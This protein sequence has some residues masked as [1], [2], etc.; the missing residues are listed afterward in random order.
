MTVLHHMTQVAP[1]TSVER[2]VK[3]ARL[4]NAKVYRDRYNWKGGGWFTRYM[5]IRVWHHNPKLWW[6]EDASLGVVTWKG[7]I[8]SILHEL[9]GMDCW[10]VYESKH[11][12][13]WSL[14]MRV[15]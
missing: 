8:G 2:I 10:Q 12:R 7:P 11:W 14:R 13:Q 9:D 5:H 4:Y 6:S 15:K 1:P 3:V